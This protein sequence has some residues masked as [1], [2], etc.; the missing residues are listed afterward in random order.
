MVNIKIWRHGGSSNFG[1]GAIDI[2]GHRTFILKEKMQA[3]ISLYKDNHLKP[4]L[5]VSMLLKK[6]IK[7]RFR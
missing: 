1:N 2:V 6:R 4:V 7:R 5:Y 3:A